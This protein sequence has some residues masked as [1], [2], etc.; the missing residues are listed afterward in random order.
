MD[1]PSAR[2]ANTSLPVFRGNQVEVYL[3]SGHTI[4]LRCEKAEFRWNSFT[5]EYVGFEFKG[6][7]EPKQ[8]DFDPRLIAGYIVK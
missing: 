5:R 6:L 4:K 1:T 2:I 8:V 7:K 3:K